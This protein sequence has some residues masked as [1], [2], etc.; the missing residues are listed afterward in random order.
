MSIPFISLSFSLIRLSRRNDSN[1][2]TVSNAVAYH[3]QTRMDARTEEYEPVLLIRMIWV[4]YKS[5]E[6][7]CKGGFG[8]VERDVMLRAISGILAR[9]PVKGKMAHALHCSYNARIV[10][11]PCRILLTPPARAAL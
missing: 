5:T 10:K 6:L 9:I 1:S 7:V 2:L 4:R 8:L 3:Q 11:P